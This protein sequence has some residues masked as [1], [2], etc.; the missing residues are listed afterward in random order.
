MIENKQFTL[1]EDKYDETIFN[2]DTAMGIIDVVEKLNEL[3]NENLQLKNENR[4]LK[5]KIKLIFGQI[6]AFRDDCITYSDFDGASTLNR[7]SDIL[8]SSMEI[9]K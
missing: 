8:K 9:W 5:E 6:K 3:N 7:L 4:E 1:S 2:N